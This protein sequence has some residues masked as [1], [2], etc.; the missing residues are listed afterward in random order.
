MRLTG[1][2]LIALAGSGALAALALTIRFW[3]R[4]GRRRRLLTRTTGVLCVQILAVAAVALAYNRAQTFYPSWSDLVA[5]G[6]AAAPPP[7]PPAAAGPADPAPTSLAWAGAPVQVSAPAGYATRSPVRFPVI[8]VL[9]G[10]EHLP[11]V[12]DAVVV[13][14]SPPAG[15]RASALA[16][17]ITGLQRRARVTEHGWVL[18]TDDR[19]QRLAKQLSA[20]S[21]FASAPV[22]VTG[23]RW[24]AALTEAADR[25][26]APLAKP[27]VP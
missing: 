3:S 21:S 19:H 20:G 16:P 24:E 15:T 7:P 23:G 14:V 27:V 25:L 18:L 17:V 22:V 9:G 5:E 8:V 11:P 10:P 26:P 2:P 4:G 1:L 13:A 12:P 6:S